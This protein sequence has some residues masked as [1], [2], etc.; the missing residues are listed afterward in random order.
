LVLDT[1]T[2]SQLPGLKEML[3]GFAAPKI[4]VDHHLTQE[5][6]A[7]FK[8]VVTDAAAAGEI[9]ADLLKRWEVP[10]DRAIAS[11]LFLAIATDTGWFQFSNTRPK[12]MRLAAELMEA[13]VDTERLY[14][15]AMQN[16]RPQRLS[17]A[18][19]ALQ[20]LELLAGNRLAVMS[21]TQG[22]FQKTA[23]GPQDTENL[24][25]L[26]MQVGDVEVSVLFVESPAN[27]PIRVNLRSKG[28]VD[29]AAFAQRYQGGGHAR[30]AG[31]KMTGDLAAARR[32]I[33][34]A[35]AAELTA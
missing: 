6:W 35:L 1:G 14:R 27:E 16:E 32:A 4:V 10:I 3:A 18:G 8:L 15:L 22:D 23:A 11:A 30:A 9:V 12:T 31:L 21:L 13:G 26:P 33:A 24:V 25:N 29:V 19:C 17:L 34:Q 2:W 28:G 7:D 5:D 20:S